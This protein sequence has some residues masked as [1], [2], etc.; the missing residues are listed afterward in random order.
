MNRERAAPRIDEHL[1]AER[2][3]LIGRLEDRRHIL[4]DL[5]IQPLGHADQFG[6]RADAHQEVVEVMGDTACEYAEALEL[7]RVQQLCLEA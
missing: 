6:A 4:A 2:R 7:L 1:A 3:R 5:R